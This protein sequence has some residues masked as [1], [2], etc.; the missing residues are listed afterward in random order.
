MSSTSYLFIIILLLNLTYGFG[1]DGHKISSS[2]AHLHLSDQAK[3][4]ISNITNYDTIIDISTWADDVKWHPKYQWSYD[5]HYADSSHDINN[6]CYFNYSQHC[7]NGLA[8]EFCVVAAIANYSDYLI[9]EVD[10]FE[11]LKFLVHFVTDLH[12]PLHLYTNYN[13][14]KD[15]PVLYFKE[16]T[17]IHRLWDE[18]LI[19]MIID[20]EMGNSISNYIEYLMKKISNE[21]SSE[22]AYWLICPSYQHIP[23]YFICPDDWAKQI[24]SLNCDHV[25]HNTTYELSD[26]YYDYNK[27]IVGKTLAM[28]GIRLA[29]LLNNIFSF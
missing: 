14:G 6:K 8:D 26:S 2:I 3:A 13:R 7:S 1:Y 27:D 5:L 18:N 10:E 12:Q 24:V 22:I 28:S 25:W 21:W 9:R 4:K 11:A 23:N 19:T 17:N 16:E 15:Y 29:N 20:R